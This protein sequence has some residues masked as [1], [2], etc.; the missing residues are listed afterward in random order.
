M[1]EAEKLPEGWAQVTF[2]DVC[3]LNP[4]KSVEG[5]LPETQ[6]TF[7]PMP[8]VSAEAGA[9][10]RP[11]TRKYL[12]VA[13]GFTSFRERDVLMAKITPCMEN[14]KAAIACG[15][16]NGL[17]F[18]STEFHVLRSNGAALPEYLFYFVRQKSFRKHA[19]E[20][21]TGSVG[22]RRVPA[23]FVRESILPLPPLAEQQR[24]VAK[25][26]QVLERVNSCRAHMDAV[27][28]LL[29]RFRQ[30][31]LAAA[32]SG[33]LTED[34]RAQNPDAETAQ[35]LVEQADDTDLPTTW[36]VVPLNKVAKV[37]SG[38]AFKKAEYSESGVKLLQIAN[39]SFGRVIWEQQNFLPESYLESHPDL[40]LREGDILM[41]LNRPLLNWRIKVAR[42]QQSDSPA[43]LYQRVGKFWPVTNGVLD[44][45]YLFLFLQSDYFIKELS[46]RLRG[47][48]QP[49]VNPPEM[50]QIAIPVA[51]IKEQREI[52]QRVQVLLNW[53]R[54]VEARYDKAR[55][56]FDR[57]SASVLAQ[58]FRGELVPQDPSDE[59][60]S[61]LLARI[62]AERAKDE[63]ARAKKKAPA[64]AAASTSGAPRGRRRKGAES[65]QLTLKDEG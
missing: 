23:D 51:P 39:V 19:E 42:L 9:I 6:V 22:Q 57:L 27:P 50:L 3:E 56:F 7:V 38:E 14:G 20:N 61:E 16:E 18:G 37:T 12:E 29:K 17:G 21:M 25:L 44:W 43:I 60:A 5:L 30:S 54:G 26:E 34:W 58:A 4:S 40:S 52:V 55:K 2:E 24:I 15:L 63:G 65:G 47:S 49:Y 1:S 11:Q 32:C 46:E 28:R 10:T 53:A 31:V 45:D 59:P 33:R 13:K 62:R 35:V 36:R 64:R 48:D 41:A 8:A